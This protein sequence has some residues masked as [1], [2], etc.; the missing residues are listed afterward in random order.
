[1]SGGYGGAPARGELREAFKGWM[2]SPGHRENLLNPAFREVGI[3]L[4]S[5]QYTPEIGTTTMYVVDFGA[6]Q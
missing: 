1:M 3:G 5:G 4:S 2:E 6:R